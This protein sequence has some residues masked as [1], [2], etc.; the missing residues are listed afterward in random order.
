MRRGLNTHKKQVAYHFKKRLYERLGLHFTKA[1][2]A[3]ITGM[4]RNG[5]AE[6]M[7]WWTTY[8]DKKCY[9]V[10]Y[11][12]HILKVIYDPRLKSLVTV[13]PWEGE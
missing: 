7:P 11:N 4:V 5:I 6:H 2:I 3:N 1:D 12:S 10:S 13:L 9:R 8:D